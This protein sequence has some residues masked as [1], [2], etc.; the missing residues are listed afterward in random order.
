MRIR[1]LF[2]P[3][4]TVLL[5]AILACSTTLDIAQITV[6]PGRFNEKQVFVGGKV[7]QTYSIPVL[8]QSLVKIDD[9][10]GQ[11][12]VKP[13]NRVPFVGEEIEVRGTLKIGMVLASQNFGVV[14]YEE[15]PAE[16]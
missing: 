12:W 6:Q 1:A 5:L 11:L 13:H 4:L 7:V 15:P 10:T 3:G 2:R 9:G 14:V 8:G 16:D